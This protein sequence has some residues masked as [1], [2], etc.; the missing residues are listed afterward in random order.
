[1]FF[2]SRYKYF[3]NALHSHMI[4]ETTVMSTG[5]CYHQRYWKLDHKSISNI[6]LLIDPIMFHANLK[7]IIVFDTT[8][9]DNSFWPIGLY[10]DVI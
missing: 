1:M 4:G 9:T 5:R 7:S 3:V 2:V 6:D 10:Q 8:F